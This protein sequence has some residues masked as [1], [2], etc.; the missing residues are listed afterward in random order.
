MFS[1]KKIFVFCLFLVLVC[2]TLRCS[3]AKGRCGGPT[4]LNCGG[5]KATKKVKTKLYFDKIWNL[6]IRYVQFKSVMYDSFMY[7]VMNRRH[8]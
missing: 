4:W 6:N 8:A 7:S 5:G 2:L 3:E 1:S